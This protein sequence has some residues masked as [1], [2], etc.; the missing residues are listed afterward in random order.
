VPGGCEHLYAGEAHIVLVSP[1]GADVDD[2]LLARRQLRDHKLLI[3]SVN[4]CII[5]Y[6]KYTNKL[7]ICQCDRFNIKDV[8][9]VSLIKRNSL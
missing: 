3:F 9:I 6:D 2:Q 8:V 1:R 5:I 7:F 4:T